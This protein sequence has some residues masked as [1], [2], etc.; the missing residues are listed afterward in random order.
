MEHH[1]L[2]CRDFM[3][4]YAE[5]RG[6]A[7]SPWTGEEEEPIAEIVKTEELLEE[8][9]RMMQADWKNAIQQEAGV[10]RW[11]FRFINTNAETVL[12]PVPGEEINSYRFSGFYAGNKI[13][14][15]KSVLDLLKNGK[16][17]PLLQGITDIALCTAEAVAQEVKYRA[18]AETAPNTALADLYLTAANVFRAGAYGDDITEFYA[19]GE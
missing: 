4:G 15:G 18:Y 17:F 14:P 9:R 16:E 11:A 13:R 19:E 8:E 10:T 6:L 2:K 12:I 3:A 1:Y 5:K 7:W